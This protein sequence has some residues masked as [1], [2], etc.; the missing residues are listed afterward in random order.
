M[1]TMVTP[2]ER[3]MKHPAGAHCAAVGCTP[4]EPDTWQYNQER[5]RE[6]HRANEHAGMNWEEC[7]L[8]ALRRSTLTFGPWRE[9]EP[10][11]HFLERR[12][13]KKR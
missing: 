9:S 3:K 7:S 1:G 4:L 5:L 8:C 6:A 2:D 11:S 12:F 13:L 10:L